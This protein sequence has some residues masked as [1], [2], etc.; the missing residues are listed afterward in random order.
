MNGSYGVP[1]AAFQK[2]LDAWPWLAAGAVVLV[3]LCVACSWRKA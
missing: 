1:L 2:V 3:L